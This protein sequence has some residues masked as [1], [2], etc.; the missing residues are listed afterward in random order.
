[1]TASR[2]LPIALGVVAVLL[3][4]LAFWFA[5]EASGLHG[6]PAARNA[7][8]TDTARTRE[9][10]GKVNDAVNALFSYDY[11]DASRTE[12]AAKGLLTGKA[13][14]QFNSMF[15]QAPAPA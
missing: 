13:V 2:L 8:L 9:V 12:Q 10:K 11:A 4:G 15:A 3:G 14:G 7:A 1:M 6:A 5:E